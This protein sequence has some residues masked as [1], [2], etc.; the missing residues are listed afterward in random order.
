M[1]STPTPR[2]TLFEAKEGGGFGGSVAEEAG[3]GVLQNPWTSLTAR[4][5]TA[6][7]PISL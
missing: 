2:R 5:L 4:S 1:S 6:D 7:K 3:G